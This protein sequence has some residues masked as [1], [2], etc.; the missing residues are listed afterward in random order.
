MLPGTT[1]EDLLYVS[2]VVN[3]VVDVYSYPKGEQVG[4]LTGLSNPGGLCADHAGNVFV[5]NAVQSGASEIVE[6]AHGGKAPTQ[7][8]SD[9]GA[10]PTGCGVSAATG[11]LAVTNQCAVKASGCSGR[12]SV[13]IYAQAKGSPK[14]YA[15]A[16]V[17]YFYFCGYDSAG[18][19]FVDGDGPRHEFRLLEL[20]R[21][22]THL[23]NV[24]LH[25]TSYSNYV[26]PGGVQWDGKLLAVGNA[27]IE[28]LHPLIYRIA[29]RDGT[30]VQIKELRG[31]ESVP[32]FFI[33]GK[34]LIAP[35]SGGGRPGRILF[36][37]YPNGVHP[38]RSI[39]SAGIPE[40]VVVSPA[41]R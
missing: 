21:K 31:A 12:G 35:A 38:M 9:P 28:R 33:D 15:P 5:T 23:F 30:I 26:D 24:R 8:L 10:S 16:F 22:G 40:G 34:T 6:F 29:P 19:L 20:R 37:H 13:L 32:Q 2:D 14:R 17:R 39:R 1:S 3:R 4:Q 27:S 7:T 25:W 18:N 36:Y 41:Q 11:D